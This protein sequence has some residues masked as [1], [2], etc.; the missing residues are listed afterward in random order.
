M[1]ENQNPVFTDE[2]LGGDGTVESPLHVLG[3]AGVS[4]ITSVDDSIE[5]TDPTG[6]TTDLSVN[7]PTTNVGTN[8]NIPIVVVDTSVSPNKLKLMPGW[9]WAQ[10][11]TGGFTLGAFP[12][13]GAGPLM[14][15]ENQSNGFILQCGSG[16]GGGTGAGT[17]TLTQAG[18]MRA[19]G[20]I[21]FSNGTT[22]T[23]PTFANNAAAV[24]GGLNPGDVYKTG[25]DPD[26]LAVVS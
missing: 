23:I 3:G 9:A 17:W 1:A 25:G 10:N 21:N 11:G 6:P 26:L 20:R 19:A 5:I 15:L 18:D 22:N 13:N 4:E 24:L 7:A 8:D 2:S 16:A 14:L 12:F